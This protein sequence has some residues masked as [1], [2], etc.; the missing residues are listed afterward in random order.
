MSKLR[1]IILGIYICCT[2]IF[3]NV[4]VNILPNYQLTIAFFY[5]FFLLLL[6][7]FHL[8]LYRLKIYFFAIL[9]PIFIGIVGFISYL[10]FDLMHFLRTYSLYFHF[11]SGLLVVNSV[12]LRYRNM[13]GLDKAIKIAL[14]IVVI[15]TLLQVGVS[16]YLGYP[17]LF[18]P[19]GKYLI[20]GESDTSRFVLSGRVR[21]TGFYWEPS[22]DAAV[23]LIL[24]N[25]L[26]IRNIDKFKKIYAAQIIIQFIVN[27]TTGLISTFLTFSLWFNSITKKYM[28]LKLFLVFSIGF[29]FVYFNFGRLA[30]ISTGGSSGFF[31]WALP[32]TCF[33]EYVVKYPLGLPLG[34]LVFQLD[35]GLFVALIYT[36]F[37]GLI[38]F[39]VFLFLFIK[40][41]LQNRLT[42]ETQLFVI[43]LMLIMIFNGAFL[44]PEM[45]FLTCLITLA[46]RSQRIID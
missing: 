28:I 43:T 32:L 14:G 15:F 39:L 44:T 1:I 31:R 35:N 41:V 42:I 33:I 40:L 21:P 11:C 4:G 12:D 23:I 7:R 22:T 20:G 38:I 27:S 5:P 45:S 9:L 16:L 46:W 2:V 24:I 3:L 17:F 10:E 30:Q 37:I 34:Q 25:Y 6:G 19:F 18:N 13:I 36:G 26:V 29:T 8:N